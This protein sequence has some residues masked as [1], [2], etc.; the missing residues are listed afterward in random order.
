MIWKQLSAVVVFHR[1][2]EYLAG[3]L[4]C[5]VSPV[6]LWVSAVAC[7]ESLAF[8]V[9]CWRSVGMCIEHQGFTTVSVIG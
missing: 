5:M 4:F 2:D 8:G 1:A 9:Q 6:N 7:I 3:F